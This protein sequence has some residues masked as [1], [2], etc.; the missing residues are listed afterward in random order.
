[1]IIII[2]TIIMISIKFIALVFRIVIMPFHILVHD[3]T[4]YVSVNYSVVKHSV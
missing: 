2:I 1:M 4:K 3:T